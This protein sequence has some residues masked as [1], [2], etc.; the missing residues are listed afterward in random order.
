MKPGLQTRKLDTR[1]AYKST[2]WGRHSWHT[3][4]KEK[5]WS[6]FEEVVPGEGRRC[7]TPIQIR[8]NKKHCNL[9]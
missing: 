1:A 9:C 8:E 4:N 3:N 2:Y 7:A 5:Q 6:T